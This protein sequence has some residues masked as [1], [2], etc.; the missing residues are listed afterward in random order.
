MLQI[1][2][3]TSLFVLLP[4]SPP[5]SQQILCRKQRAV[6]GGR[7]SDVMVPDG[8]PRLHFA[9]VRKF[10]FQIANAGIQRLRFRVVMWL[11]LSAGE[12]RKNP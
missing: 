6:S 11:L 12:F 5:R 7:S 4:F 10:G 8:F 2:N 9:S 1:G 3:S